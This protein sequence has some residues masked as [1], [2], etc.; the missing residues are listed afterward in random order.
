MYTGYPL[1]YTSRGIQ[2]RWHKKNTKH[3]TFIDDNFMAETKNFM[4]QAMAAII[5]ALFRSLGRPD[6]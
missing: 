4:P 1:C 2:Q 6:S 5:E 3:N